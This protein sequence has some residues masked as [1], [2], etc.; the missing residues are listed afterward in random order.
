M[1][2]T[3]YSFQKWLKYAECM[4][5]GMSV[6]RTAQEVGISVPTAF[7]WRHKILTALRNLPKPSLTGIVE[8]DE[9]FFLESQKGQRN[10]PRQPRRRGA[11]APLRGISHHQVCVLVARDRQTSTVSGVVGRGRV[12]AQQIEAALDDVL[13]D[14]V[15]CSDAAAGYRKYASTKKIP[16]Q[17]L[18]ATRGAKKYGLYHPLRA[19]I[20][21]GAEAGENVHVNPAGK[22]SWENPSGVC[23]F[24]GRRPSGRGAWRMGGETVLRG[25]APTPEPPERSVEVPP[26]ARVA[27]LHLMVGLPCSGKTTLARELEARHNALRLTADEWHIRL[28]GQDYG[29]GMSKSDEAQH[30]DRHNLVASLMWDVAARVLVLGV[31]VVF[32]LGCWVRSER[33]DYRSQTHALGAAFKIHFTETPEDVLLE[34][35]RIR[36][37]QPG[38]TFLIPEG[39]LR[40]WMRLFEP[41]SR[42]ELE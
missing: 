22:G 15:L 4:S 11:S 34:R 6:R 2:G 33:D 10:L 18:N 28:F 12:T 29:E 31:D 16:L 35:L 42:D 32:D 25:V 40:E 20:D 36:N 1:A 3:H 19:I 41:P 7:Y 24:P 13:H 14:C 37:S 39:K 5:Q 38:S 30:D 27:T 17:V 9:T 23:L 8:A 26:R 21:P